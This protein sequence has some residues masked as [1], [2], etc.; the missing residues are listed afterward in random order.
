MQIQVRSKNLYVPAEVR[1]YVERRVHFALG[2]FEQKV[3]SVMVRLEDVN[4]S[5]RGIDQQCRIHVKGIPS[6]NIVAEQTEGNIYAAINGAAE[7]AARAVR[8]TVGR[9]RDNRVLLPA[10]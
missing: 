3:Q 10:A 6:L 1:G 4:G 9:L 7:R 2:R 8:K 5:R